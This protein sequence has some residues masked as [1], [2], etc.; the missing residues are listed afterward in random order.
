ML[1]LC[2]V[3]L[4]VTL[5]ILGT[6]LFA[7]D[8]PR[9]A[10]FFLEMGWIRPPHSLPMQTHIHTVPVTCDPAAVMTDEK[11]LCAWSN[12]LTILI[13]CCL[14]AHF[15]P[16]A[17]YRAVCGVLMLSEVLLDALLLLCVRLWLK[18]RSSWSL[19]STCRLFVLDSSSCTVWL[20]GHDYVEVQSCHP[21][22]HRF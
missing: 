2:S 21:K 5:S 16:A 13:I 7:L 11:R 20:L 17:A 4:W 3:H 12:S 22:L 18:P 14:V 19:S 1:K 15:S 6:I 10:K 8:S 9:D